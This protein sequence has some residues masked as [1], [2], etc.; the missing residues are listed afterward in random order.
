MR[1]K[2]YIDKREKKDVVALMQTLVGHGVKEIISHTLPG[3]D[4]MY[5]DADTDEVLRIDE[6][7]RVGD[8]VSSLQPAHLQPKRLEDQLERLKTSGVPELCLLV[9]GSFDGYEPRICRALVSITDNLQ[10]DGRVG[11]MRLEGV[12]ELPHYVKRVVERLER[13]GPRVPCKCTVPEPNEKA[14]FYEVGVALRKNRLTTPRDRYHTWLQLVP[15]SS[16]DRATA[17]T[18]K[19]PTHGD[20]RTAL[21]VGGKEAIT[22]IKVKGRALPHTI[23][24]ALYDDF[25]T[26]CQSPDASDSSESEDE[27]A[28]MAALRARKRR[29]VHADDLSDTEDVK[30][31]VR[32]KKRRVVHASDNE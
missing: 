14:D 20:L 26:T 11:V 18:T 28:V 1:V 21:R 24:D 32:V 5:V 23:A 7:K 2:V 27:A 30:A 6:H 16:A 8:F 10:A 29:T 17:I 13:D 4:I 3:G 9:T 25:V 19:Y 22:S 15:D 31:A 12:E